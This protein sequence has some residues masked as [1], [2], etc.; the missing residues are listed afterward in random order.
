[1]RVMLAL[2]I[3]VGL[4][5]NHSAS[6][7]ENYMPPGFETILLG[8]NTTELLKTRP[9]ISRKDMDRSIDFSARDLLLFEKL[10][11]RDTGYRGIN[12]LIGDGRLI[13]V[14]FAIDTPFG[15]ESNARRELVKKYRSLWGK[16]HKR[17]A[18]MDA[19]RKGK[20]LP[21]LVWIMGDVEIALLLPSDRSKDD[22]K[23]IATGLQIRVLSKVAQPN[24]DLP[25]NQKTKEAFFREHGIDD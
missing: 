9:G 4:T 22:R 20:H 17:K 1:M 6:S 18:P 24:D 2:A 11:P 13:M 16:E 19:I 12:Y 5:T 25:M 23:T 15:K 14:N 8:M 3:A 7:A 10:E 21:A